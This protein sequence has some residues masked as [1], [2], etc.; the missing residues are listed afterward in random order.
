MENKILNL[1]CFKIITDADIL[2]PDDYIKE[3]SNR[4]FGFLPY[5]DDFG[6]F[7]LSIRFKND[8]I[9]DIIDNF[10]KYYGDFFEIKDTFPISTH[11]NTIA[12]VKELAK[13]IDVQY[14]R[15]LKIKY[16]TKIVK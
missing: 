8:S 15:D 6:P 3:L 7:L 10:N 1:L 12:Y 13:T 2:R 5:N 16:L 4:Y 14:L 11:P 9:E